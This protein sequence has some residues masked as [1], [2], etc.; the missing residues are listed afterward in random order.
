MYLLFIIIYKQN[1]LI[2]FVIIRGS[3]GTKTAHEVR[4]MTLDNQ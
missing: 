4:I 2:Q 3:I 1:T